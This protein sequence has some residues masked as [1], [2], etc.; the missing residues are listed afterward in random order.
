M[1]L[2]VRPLEPFGAELIAFDLSQVATPAGS[3]ALLEALTTHALLVAHDL[4]LSPADLVRVGRALGDLEILPEPEKRNPDHP[5]IFDLTNVRLDGEIVE[6]TEPQAVFLRGTERWHTDSSFRAIPCLSTMLYA[7]EVPASGG[8][9]EFADMRLAWDALP[10]GRQAELDGLQVVHSY[11]FS[12]ANNPGELEPWTEEER[13]KY[14]PATHPLVRT[15]ADGRRSL[16]L[17]G[18]ASHIESLPIDEGR[19]LLAEVVDAAAGPDR[20]YAHRWQAG[21]LVMWD[22]RSTLHRL[23]PYDIAHDRRVMR[24]VTVSGT[25]P[26]M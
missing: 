10:A 16:Y 3:V 17:G 5:E 18:H 26:V 1:G 8:D 24:R 2:D 22:N 19:A 4:T 15:H 9:T 21:D 23:R 11:E 6:F 7:V 12:R 25:E 13:A 14:P 20:I